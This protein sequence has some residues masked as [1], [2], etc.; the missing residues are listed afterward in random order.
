M[1][2]VKGKE[3][4]RLGD[5]GFTAVELDGIPV[6]FDEDCTSAALY[7][8]NMSNFKLGIHKDANFK[9]VKKSEPTDQHLSVNHIV[10]A[11]NTVVNRRAS[12]AKLT[13][14]TE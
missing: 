14:K 12:L 8:L 10:F 3:S 5:G 2:P 13:G 4:T 6:T 11:G 7:W 9:V 1:N